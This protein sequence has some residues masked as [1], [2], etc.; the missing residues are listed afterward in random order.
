MMNPSC[1][2]FDN[3][4][5]DSFIPHHPV[6]FRAASM[7]WP[8]AGWPKAVLKVLRAATVWPVPSN[9]ASAK[10]GTEASP[11]LDPYLKVK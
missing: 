4:V 3:K 11:C 5:T 6:A 7:A 10:S 2:Q 9:C 8:A 1:T